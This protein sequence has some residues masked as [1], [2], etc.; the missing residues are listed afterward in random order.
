MRKST[1][2]STPSTSGD[3]PS[4]IGAPASR[5]LNGVGITALLALALWREADIRALHGVGPKALGILREALR[6][7]G[8]AFK[9]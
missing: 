8:L 2:A 4:N 3:L 9:D 5:A 7:R 1:K 6:T